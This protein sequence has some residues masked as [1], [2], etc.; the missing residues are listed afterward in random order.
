M[1]ET[2]E[3]LR[4]A[5]IE[6]QVG[7]GSPPAHWIFYSGTAQFSQQKS[8]HEQNCRLIVR[9]GLFFVKMTRY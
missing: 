7:P 1:S 3:D 9:P 6:Y 8:L 5:I 4:D 2:T